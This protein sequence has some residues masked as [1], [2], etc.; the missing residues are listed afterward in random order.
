[1]GREGFQLHMISQWS[2]ENPESSCAASDTWAGMEVQARHMVF[3]GHRW[4]QGGTRYQQL[5]MNVSSP[6]TWLSQP[7]PQQGGGVPPQP[8]RVEILHTLWVLLIPG[9]VGATVCACVVFSAVEQL[10]YLKVSCLARL[11]LSGPL[12]TKNRL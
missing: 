1:M 9:G 8:G 5:G 4:G 6:P 3:T 11:S 2:G 7:L 12:V 10:Y